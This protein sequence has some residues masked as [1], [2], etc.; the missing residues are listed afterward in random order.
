[1]AFI[2]S[3][4]T[5]VTGLGGRGIVSVNLSLSPQI[6][7][8]FDLGYTDPFDTN[9]IEQHSLS[10]V[11][12]AP[13]PTHS[14]AASTLCQDAN[15][16]TINITANA[17]GAGND[18]NVSYDFFVNS[19]SYSKDVQAFGQETWGMITRPIPS[20]G[21]DFLMIRGIAEGQ[22][23]PDS[24][25]GQTTGINISSGLITG[26]EISVTAGNPGLGQANDVT[27]GVVDQIGGGTG[28]YDGYTGNGNVT[29]PYTPIPDIA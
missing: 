14:V 24:S 1:M 19:Y 2:I 28:K 5:F 13:G 22:T 8:L 15:S 23:T 10:V 7:R 27:F 12:Y 20:T 3:Q 17:C 4:S 11:R 6:Q 29:I 16:L 26:K 9:T 25:G 21:A 18:F